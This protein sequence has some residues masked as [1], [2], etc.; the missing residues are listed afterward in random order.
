MQV[1]DTV[2]VGGGTAGCIVAARR[3]EQGDPAV[4]VSARGVV[5]E[6]REQGSGRDQGGGQTSPER[7][8][9]QSVCAL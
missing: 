2:V 1:V 3:S 4:G 5:R 6:G 8:S 7:E 9:N